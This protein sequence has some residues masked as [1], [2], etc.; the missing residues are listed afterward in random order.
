M[1]LWLV[2]SESAAWTIADASDVV[3]QIDYDAAQQ[4]AVAADGCYLPA[5]DSAESPAPFLQHVLSVACALLLVQLMHE[6]VA[7]MD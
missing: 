4:L 6:V 2:A 5:G 7:L 3:D 1:L